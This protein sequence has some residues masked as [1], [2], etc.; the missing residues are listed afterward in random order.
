MITKSDFL[1]PMSNLDIFAANFNFGLGDKIIAATGSNNRLRII[2]FHFFCF[3]GFVLFL[4]VSVLLH[5]FIHKP[6]SVPC[7]QD[8]CFPGCFT[9]NL[10]PSLMLISHTREDT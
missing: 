9:M 5:F 2:E 10:A 8:T 6:E 4:H 7:L 3:G 1:G